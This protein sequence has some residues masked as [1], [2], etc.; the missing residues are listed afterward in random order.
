MIRTGR[1]GCRQ[2]TVDRFS[3]TT[4][5]SGWASSVSA[6]V[7]ID[8]TRGGGL[9]AGSRS[10]IRTYRYLPAGDHLAGQLRE[11]NRHR[12]ERRD[13]DAL[14]RGDRAVGQP[15]TVSPGRTRAI[16]RWWLCIGSNKINDPTSTPASDGCILNDDSTATTSD[17]DKTPHDQAQSFAQVPS[18]GCA[19]TRSAT[20]SGASISRRV[21][22]AQ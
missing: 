7:R 1:M 22:R 16:T 11:A 13:V 18:V 4:Q 14:N 15:D 2:G 12:A 20:S 21:H 10:R 6:S 3:S 17:E 8:C 9:A 5:C 19:G